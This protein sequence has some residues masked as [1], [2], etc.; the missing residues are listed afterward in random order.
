L[1]QQADFLSRTFIIAVAAGVERVHWFIL[2]DLGTNKRDPEQNFGLVDAKG[3]PKPALA[4]LGATTRHL[5][6]ARF[7]GV[8]PGVGAYQHVWVWQTPWI[9]NT[10]LLTIWCDTVMRK[11]PPQWT[12]L[13]GEVL[14][15]EDLWGGPVSPQ[16]FRHT[17]DGW[18]ALPGEDPL[19]VYVSRANMPNKLDPL[20]M[21]LRPR[22]K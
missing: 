2:R 10:A 17:A 4:A 16:R 22:P 13:P 15:A 18:Q 5:E 19:F 3:Q 20:P 7:Q 21:S 8:L 14:L 6:R 1:L 12:G 11:G 9:E